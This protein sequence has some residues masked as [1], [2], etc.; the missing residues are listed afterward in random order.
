[1]FEGTP[2]FKAT[3]SHWDIKRVNEYC[4]IVGFTTKDPHMDN[5]IRTSYIELLNLKDGWVKTRNSFYKLGE[6]AGQGEKP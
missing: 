2:A 5:S 1:M 6:A 3:I 4:V